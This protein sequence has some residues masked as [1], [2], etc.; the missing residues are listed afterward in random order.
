[1]LA[2]KEVKL[3]KRNEGTLRRGRE[4]N[5]VVNPTIFP[6]CKVQRLCCTLSAYGLSLS[7][8]IWMLNAS[9]PQPSSLW[10]KANNTDVAQEQSRK[11]SLIKH[12]GKPS[13]KHEA[14]WSMKLLGC[15]VI[16]WS[17]ERTGAAA[18]GIPAY[19]SLAA[20]S[21]AACLVPRHGNLPQV[22][23]HTRL[24]EITG[25]LCAS[26]FFHLDLLFLCRETM[27]GEIWFLSLWSDD[28]LRRKKKCSFLK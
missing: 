5:S 10:N 20:P 13:A 3:T 22:P 9:V 24:P 19:G 25:T 12:I 27:V 2:L 14:T 7:A 1:M 4:Q 23:N 17:L 28:S 26:L 18:A 8:C 11:D 6:R 21:R 15:K 16:K